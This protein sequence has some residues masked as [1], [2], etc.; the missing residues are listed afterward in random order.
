MRWGK[1]ATQHW[2]LPD[3]RSTSPECDYFKASKEGQREPSLVNPKRLTQT[4]YQPMHHH[5]SMCIEQRTW[6][7]T[8]SCRM[9]NHYASCGFKHVSRN[10]QSS[11]CAHHSWFCLLSSW[12]QVPPWPRKKSPKLKDITNAPWVMSTHLVQP[13]F[14]RS[15]I[16]LHPRME[17]PA[18][19]A[20]WISEPAIAEKSEL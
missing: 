10:D 17:K 4:A 5:G 1:I 11:L 15:T 13:V 20:G 8:A 18:R 6:R 7:R 3:I 12:H 19:K 14:H 2:S 9:T 16:R